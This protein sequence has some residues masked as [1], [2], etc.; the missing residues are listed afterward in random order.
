MRKYK[1][2]CQYWYEL[3]FILVPFDL[4]WKMVSKFTLVRIFR[5]VLWE[6]EKIGKHLWPFQTDLSLDSHVVVTAKLQYSCY[7]LCVCL[8]VFHHFGKN[9]IISYWMVYMLLLFTLQHSFDITSVHMFPDIFQ[10]K[11]PFLF[12]GLEKKV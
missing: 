12:K 8:Q 1:W 9:W 2:N 3:T 4:L 6:S 5:F 11:I 10:H 7:C